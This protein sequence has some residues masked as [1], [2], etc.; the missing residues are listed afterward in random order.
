M[1]HPLLG[2]WSFQLDRSEGFLRR[3]ACN[4]TSWEFCLPIFTQLRQWNQD[5]GG[6]DTGSSIFQHEPIASY[7]VNSSNYSIISPINYYK[8]K[9]K[10]WFFICWFLVLEKFLSIRGREIHSI[11]MCKMAFIFF[12]LFLSG[13]NWQSIYF[14]FREVGISRWLGINH[15]IFSM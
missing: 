11:L 9:K 8:K 14:I 10:N 4:R 2:R 3:S 5:G 6:L 7:T 13:Q 12:V 1:Q 15:P